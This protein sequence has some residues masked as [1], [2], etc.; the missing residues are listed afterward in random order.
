M[1]RQMTF[2]AKGNAY[3]SFISG[4]MV[5]KSGLGEESPATLPSVLRTYMEQLNQNDQLQDAEDVEDQAHRP[6]QAKRK[7]NK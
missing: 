3:T 1:M 7:R 4:T 5:L 2:V 6:N